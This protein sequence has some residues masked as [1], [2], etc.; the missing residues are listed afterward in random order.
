MWIPQEEPIFMDFCDLWGTIVCKN[1]HSVQ[2]SSD[3]KK[4]QGARML[5]SCKLV[6]W[7]HPHIYICCD[8]K[9]SIWGDS[10]VITNNLNWVN[11]N[12]TTEKTSIKMAEIEPTKL[13]D[14]WNEPSEFSYCVNDFYYCQGKLFAIIA[15]TNWKQNPD[16]CLDAHTGTELGTQF[17]LFY[18]NYSLQSLSHAADN[19]GHQGF[20]WEA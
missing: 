7:Q 5:Q 16:L 14:W 12:H 11:V 9:I 8:L 1:R 6:T 4:N 13:P 2:F 19:L 10:A 17:R 18:P 15:K 20:F 3:I